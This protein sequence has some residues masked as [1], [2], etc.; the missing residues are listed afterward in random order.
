M[1][2]ASTG[3]RTWTL[4]GILVVLIVS[5]VFFHREINHGLA[6]H[7]FLSSKSPR[8][9]LF[10]ELATQSH[11]PAKFLESCWATGKIPHREFVAAYLKEQAVGNSPLVSRIE[12]LVMAC[13]ID[14]DASVR[15]LGLAALDAAH[16]SRMFEVA[17][18]Q[19]DD[20]DPLVRDL[21]LDY[22]RKCDPKRA[23]P[24]LVRLLDDPDLGIVT[25]AE[26]SLRHLSGEDYGVRTSMAI[27]TAEEAEWGQ[28]NSNKIATIH[29]GIEKRK[30]WWR[31]HEKDYAISS[32]SPVRFTA[33]VQAERPPAADFTLAD[34]NGRKA[35]LSDFRGKVVLLN[36]W[37]TWCT[38]CLAEIPDLIALQNKLG[39][40]VAIIGVALDGVTD[41]HGHIPDEE[42]DDKSHT[43]SASLESI[44]ATVERAVKLRGI[45]YRVLLDPRSSV[46]GQ[47]NGGEL[48]T[49]VIFD[50]D[51]R[52]RRR[53]LGER[54]VSV[55][56]AMI[57][58]SGKALSSD[59]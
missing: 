58:E 13:A 16:N 22:L 36:F 40:Q 49:T 8:E 19:L 47:Y 57:A 32:N 53:F 21:G 48:P 26:V 38:A 37:A 11:D 24:I 7:L 9:E 46:G 3:I 34:L 50:T 23:V 20:L 15:E 42:A 55:F 25:R 41:E 29:Q 45:N 4:A 52:V 28:I 35:S 33:S 54:S 12:P 17:R 18:A 5:W 1:K 59:N 30:V 44:R 27:A 6:L 2:S 31:A 39:D 56:E 43:A 51:G 14:G 10:Q